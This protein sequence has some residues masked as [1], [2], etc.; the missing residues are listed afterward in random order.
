VS[1]NV[2]VHEV[3]PADQYGVQADL[4]SRAI[5]ENSAVPT[6]PEDAV[7]NLLVLEWIFAEATA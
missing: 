6:D 3:G 1:P 2:E 4:F 5:R 7:G